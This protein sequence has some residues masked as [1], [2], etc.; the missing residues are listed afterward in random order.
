ME[1][2]WKKPD[3]YDKIEQISRLSEFFECEIEQFRF[4]AYSIMMS[5][6]FLG[7]S[8]FVIK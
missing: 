5:S 3:S 2:I 7:W 4:S 1:M 8:G 6:A